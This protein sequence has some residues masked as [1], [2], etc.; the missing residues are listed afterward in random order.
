MSCDSNWT[1]IL[2]GDYLDYANSYEARVLRKP[3]A[4]ESNSVYEEMI[5]ICPDDVKTEVIDTTEDDSMRQGNYDIVVLAA[6]D[7]TVKSEVITEANGQSG[8]S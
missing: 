5:E 2:P 7:L 4:E 3:V 8:E 1:E 6:D